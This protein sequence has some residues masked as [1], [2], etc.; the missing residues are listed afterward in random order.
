MASYVI[1]QHIAQEFGIDM[2]VRGSAIF[3]LREVAN[4]VKK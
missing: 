2:S 3:Q 4:H 1:L